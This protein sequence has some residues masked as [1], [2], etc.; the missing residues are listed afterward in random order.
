MKH[1]MLMLLTILLLSTVSY[2]I[3]TVS[4]NHLLYTCVSFHR[5]EFMQLF[6]WA[7]QVLSQITFDPSPATCSARTFLCFRRIEFL[8]SS[9]ASA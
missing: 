8:I 2:F 5:A 9:T 1:L 4:V 3:L 7:S 6:L